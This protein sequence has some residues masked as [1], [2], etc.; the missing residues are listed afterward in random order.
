M[1]W[2]RAGRHGLLCPAPSGAL[3]RRAPELHQ[4]CAAP[5]STP[6]PPS[7]ALRVAWPPLQGVALFAIAHSRALHILPISLITNLIR[8]EEKRITMPQ[9]VMLWWSGLRGG[10]AFALSVSAA[11]KHGRDG[12][13][14][15]TATFLICALTVLVNGGVAPWLLQKLKLLKSQ[16]DVIP[17]VPR[18]GKWPRHCAVQCRPPSTCVLS[19][20]GA[21]SLKSPTVSWESDLLLQFHGMHPVLTVHAA[22]QSGMQV[23]RNCLEY[24]A[25]ESRG[26]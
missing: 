23:C 6:Q 20:G 7:T 26:R 15:E 13:F 12:K 17:E 4:C 5:R 18:A 2:Q 21:L 9:Q 10:V 8:P 16:Q 24:R 11:G 14:M 3:P 22:S 1:G 19:A 25:A